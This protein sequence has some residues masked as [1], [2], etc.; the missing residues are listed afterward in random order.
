MSAT[1]LIVALLRIDTKSYPQRSNEVRGT[2][3][4]EYAGQLECGLDG[5]SAARIG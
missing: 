2:Y 3:L 5:A 4:H 1:Y